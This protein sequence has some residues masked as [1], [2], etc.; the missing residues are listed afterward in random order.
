MNQKDSPDPLPRRISASTDSNEDVQEARRFT[1]GRV[2]VLRI[3]SAV[4]LI[5]ILVV[6]YLLANRSNPHST[7]ETYPVPVLANQSLDIEVLDGYGNM[8]IA[9]RVTDYLR[10]QGYDVVEMK[11]NNDGIVDRSFVL[12]RSGKFDAAKKVAAVLGISP[13]KVFQKIDRNLYLDVTVIVGK[14]FSKLKT[15]QSRSQRSSH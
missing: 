3:S 1:R 7:N 2:T 8:K 13:N 10:S 5:V 4:F 14:D 6:L 12:D 15:F 9:Q 11:K